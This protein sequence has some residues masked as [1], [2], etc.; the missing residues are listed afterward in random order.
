M[1]RFLA[2]AA[3][4]ATFAGCGTTP[5]PRE[6]PPVAAPPASARPLPPS[7]DNAALPPA[8]VRG[9]SRWVPVRYAELPG[10]ADDALH[11]AWNAWLRSCERPPPPW[12]A[13]CPQVRQ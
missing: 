5:L 13:L 12:S 1:L 9:A 2:L 4:V 8:L 3:I 6:A 10:F 7:Q 11:E